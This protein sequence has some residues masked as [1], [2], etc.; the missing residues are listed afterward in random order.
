MQEGYQYGS[1]TV[2]ARAPRDRFNKAMWLCRCKCGTEKVIDAY[3]LASGRSKACRPCSALVVNAAKATHRRSGSKL[4]RTWQAI[5]TRCYNEKWEKTYKYH[6]ALGVTV[7]DGWLK[8]FEAFAA[9]VGEPP[10]PLHT[11]DRIDPWG[12]Y[13]PGNV[14]WATQHE[15][16]QNTRRSKK[17][18]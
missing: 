3:N 11:L 16:M 9:Y 17:S 4:Y 12:N 18:A 1:W 13:E 5:K 10:T 15:Q 6:G 8:D 7:H 2:V 14:R